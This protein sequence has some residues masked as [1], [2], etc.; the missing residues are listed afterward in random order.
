MSINYSLKAFANDL[1]LTYPTECFH[2]LVE[3]FK[4]YFAVKRIGSMRRT[5]QFIKDF[6]K[7]I[8]Q[9]VKIKRSEKS[10]ET[11]KQKVE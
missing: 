5:S 4:F 8:K 9:K 11:I 10:Q 2:F 6:I 3:S 7:F 1:G